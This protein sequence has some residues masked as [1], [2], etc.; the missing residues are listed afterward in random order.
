MKRRRF[1]G[2]AAGSA[3]LT[4]SGLPQAQ[5]AAGEGDAPRLLV[6]LLRGGMDGLAAVPPVGEAKL[7]GIRP[8][9]AV[10]RALPLDGRFGLHP[11][12]PTAHALWQAGQ[13]A[14]VHACGFDYSG[15]SHFEG[16]DVMQSGVMTPYTSASGWVGR[17]M[18]AAGL[19]GG[20]AISIPMPLILRG[21]PAA[22]T[23][24]PNWMAAPRPALGADVQRLWG[25]DPQLAPYARHLGEDL[26]AGAGLRRLNL[27]AAEFQEARSPASLAR[28]A[29][30]RMREADGPRVGLI[31]IEGGFDTHAGQGGDSGLHATKLREFDAILE[32]FRDA[33]GP[34]WRRSLVVSVTEFGRTA[35]ENGTGGT[36]HGLG[37]CIF[38]AGGLVARAAVVAD[39]RGLDPEALFQRRDLPATIDACAVYARVLEG[40]FGLTAER[41]YAEV[42]RHR[43]DP[44]LRDLLA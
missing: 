34:A 3:A 44:A 4:L 36:D 32:A 33:M 22:A 43:P 35:A 25:A 15:R 19:G 1:L 10:T 28:L 12:L 29:A 40:V 16:Q 18:Q 41:V 20:V 30:E 2:H 24:Y 11:A 17:A 7:P 42:L 13:L 23:E 14:V 37:S 21:D 5:A 26:Q 27:R 6:V 31:D 8:T 38:L 9:I 39:W